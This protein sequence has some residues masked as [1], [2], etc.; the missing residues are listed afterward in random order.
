MIMVL[1]SITLVTSTS[2]ITNDCYDARNGVDVVLFK[3][4]DENDDMRDSLDT[5]TVSDTFTPKVDSTTV[6]YT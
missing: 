4:Y 6:V 3:R 5:F 2:M 1:L